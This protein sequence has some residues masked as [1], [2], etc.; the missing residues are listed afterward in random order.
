MANSDK[1]F[2]YANDDGG[3][4]IVMKGCLN[5]HNLIAIGYR[6]SSKKT[7]FFVM[8]DGAGS[9]SPGEPYQMK[10]VDEHGNVGKFVFFILF[11]SFINVLIYSSIFLFH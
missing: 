1:R 11:N 8:T 6:Y 10:F 3:I 2:I 7:L 9:T 4:S 5:E